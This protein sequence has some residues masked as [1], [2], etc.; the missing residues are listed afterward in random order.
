MSAPDHSHRFMSVSAGLTYDD[1]LL[2]P[3]YSEVLPNEVALGAR[4]SERMVLHIPLL[5]SAMD[6]VSEAPMAIAMARLG[7]LAVIHK[8]MTPQQ[9]AAEVLRVKNEDP[10][11]GPRHLLDSA[12]RLCCAAAVGPAGDCD[13]RVAL[14]TAAGVDVLVIDTAHGHSRNVLQAT[15][16]IRDR[17]PDLT[18]VAGNVATAEALLAL[19]EAGA[20]AVKVG[21]GPGSIC[22]TRI[23]AG[24]G[25]PQMTAVLDC[26]AAARSVGIRVIADGGLKHSGDLVKALAA[27]ADCVMAGSLLAGTDEAPGEVLTQGGHRFKAYR[28]MGSLG[29]MQQGSKDRYFQDAIT[30]AGKL[31]PEGVEARVPCKGPVADVVHQLMGGL[32]AGMGYTGCDNVLALRERTRFVRITPAG[33]SESHVHGVAMSRPSPNYAP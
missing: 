15:R 29:A 8:N 9:Q 32:R 22:T 20:D 27:G 23:V 14:L 24:V 26:A 12:G 25:V 3:L 33:L 10:G 4:L 17:F 19:A 21:I 11:A 1:V 31:V 13:E 7:G 30:D 6:S 28:G 5:A 2:V 18:L 16:R